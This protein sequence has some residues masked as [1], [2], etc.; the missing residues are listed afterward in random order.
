MRFRIVALFTVALITA[1]QVAVAG[2]TLP[3]ATECASND[4][5]DFH[6]TR[7]DAT[8]AKGLQLLVEAGGEKGVRHGADTVSASG[9]VSICLFNARSGEMVEVQVASASFK[10]LYPL[11]GHLPLSREG[12]PEIVVCEVGRDCNQLT[13]QQ[14]A[15]LIQKAQPRTQAMTAAEKQA[16]FREWADYARQLGR[17]TNSDYAQLLGTLLRKERQVSAASRASVLLRRFVNQAREVLD[18]FDRHAERV[19]SHFDRRELDEMNKAYLAYNPVFDE[20]S[21]RADSYLKD[22]GDAWNPG[23]SAE[24]RALIDE[25]LEIHKQGI[26]TLNGMNTLINDCIGKR[27]ECPG[28]EAS[29]AAVQAAR[30]TVIEVTLPRLDRFE[31]RSTQWLASLDERLFGDPAAATAAPPATVRKADG[32]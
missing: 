12:S 19:L 14:I 24:L 18:R 27:P 20:L 15:A 32:K 26:Y 28:P 2:P 30:R 31:K 3:S 4:S 22:A 16:F 13:T 5:F 25:A 17:E 7:P 11:R 21:E 8:P 10:I 6:V 9:S 23:V 1:A 29:R